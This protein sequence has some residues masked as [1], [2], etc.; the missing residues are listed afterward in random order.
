MV[1]PEI[2]AILEPF[3]GSSVSAYGLTLEA[4]ITTFAIFLAS[5]LALRFSFRNENKEV[6]LGVFFSMLIILAFFGILSFFT[7]GIP[8]ILIALYFFY[9]KRGAGNI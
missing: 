7:V 2:L 3:L 5:I 4:I 6:G 8:L 9:T 1:S